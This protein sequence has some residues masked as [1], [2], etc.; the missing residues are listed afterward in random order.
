MSV[1][2]VAALPLGDEWLPTFHVIVVSALL[3][4]RPRWSLPVVAAVVAAQAP[5]GLLLDSQVQAASSYFAV[6]VL[7]RSAAVFVPIWLVGAVRRLDEARE[8]LA[9][10]SVVRE[11]MRIDA[12]LRETLGTSLRS[13]A[14]R[15]Q[16]V[17]DALPGDGNGRFAPAEKE[18]VDLVG[19]ARLTLA[20]VRQT[21]NGYQH[22]SL[23]SEIETASVLLTAT[24]VDTRIVLPAEGIPDMA[25]DVLRSTLAVLRADVARILRS[26][27][28][29]ACVITVSHR[30]GRVQIGIEQAVAP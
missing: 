30:S 22:A 26:D 5:L 2:V 7:W 23:A 19:A 29:A 15:G 25:S 9:E 13:I 27:D 11:R 12:E 16:R 20:Q 3:V 18:L 6:T 4:L 17:A 24:G 8:A 21:V 28:M 14:S 10:E 1:M